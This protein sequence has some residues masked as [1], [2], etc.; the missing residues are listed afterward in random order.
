MIFSNCDIPPISDISKAAVT[1]CSPPSAT[2]TAIVPHVS[3]GQVLVERP[4]VDVR[5][6]VGVELDAVGARDVEDVTVFDLDVLGE[7]V[8]DGVGFHVEGAV[9]HGA[10]DD[11]HDLDA[12]AAALARPAARGGECGVGVHVVDGHLLDAGLVDLAH[13]VDLARAVARDDER[14]VRDAQVLG[15][16]VHED[17]LGL[18]ERQALHLDATD[19]RQLDVAVEADG[20]AVDADAIGKADGEDAQ[21][22]AAEEAVARRNRRV[23]QGCRLEHR[24]GLDVARAVILIVRGSLPADG[25]RRCL[26]G[27]RRCRSGLGDVCRRRRSRERARSRLRRDVRGRRSRRRGKNGTARQQERR[28]GESRKAVLHDSKTP[29]FHIFVIDARYTILV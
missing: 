3:V 9:V 8:A 27:G 20:Q 4:G 18:V 5:Q 19:V 15:Q 17:G 2:S 22:V 1:G 23:A 13:D 26:H 16:G 12:G 28:D 11:A 7:V 25:G 10:V 29:C 24:L 21:R 6:D 14:E